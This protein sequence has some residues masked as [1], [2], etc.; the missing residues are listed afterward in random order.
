[1]LL[2]PSPALLPLLMAER[3]MLGG[4][5][6]ACDEL[7]PQVHGRHGVYLVTTG[8]PVQ[9]PAAVA[10]FVKELLLDGQ[11]KVP[12]HRLHSDTFCVLL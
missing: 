12:Y 4:L 2:P 9:A 8:R 3:N 1:M 10:G 7:R 6:L 11:T 5:Q